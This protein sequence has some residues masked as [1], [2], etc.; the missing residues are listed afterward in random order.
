MIQNKLTQTDTPP[1]DEVESICNAF[2]SEYNACRKK[3][4]GAIRRFVLFKKKVKKKTKE[5]DE[6]KKKEYEI[7]NGDKHVKEKGE[8]GKYYEHFNTLHKMLQK[9][10]NVAPINFIKAQFHYRGLIKPFEVFDSSAMQYY[11]TF[12][13]KAPNECGVKELKQAIEN[14]DEYMKQQCLLWGVEYNIENYF[15]HKDEGAFITKAAMLLMTTSMP[16]QLFLS[17]SETYKNILRTMPYDIRM[18]LPQI[19]DDDMR[20]QRSHYINHKELL[21]TF[22]EIFTKQESII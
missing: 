2:Q 1:L 21:T 13:D 11:V 3:R 20:A 5:S 9:F 6:P 12:M 19:N 7:G 4:G 22:K 16:S 18:D 10:P 8:H 17:N 15:N 14:D